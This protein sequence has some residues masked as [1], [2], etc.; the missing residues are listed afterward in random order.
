MTGQPRNI[1][2]ISGLGADHRIFENLVP[3]EGYRLK[4]IPWITQQKNESI[5]HYAARM[6]A[7]IRDPEPVLIGVS[8]GGM[9]SVEIAKQRPGSQVIMVSSI[10]TKHEK[11]FYFRAAS[12]FRL[13]KIL[14][15]R[16]YR[17]LE[18]LENYNLGI[19]TTDEKKLAREYRKN[20]D[21]NYSNWAI[22]RIIHWQNEFIPARIV[23][24][25]GSKDHIFPIKYVEPGYVIEG[26]GH[27]MIHNRA[28][29]IS[30]I[31]SDT[32]Q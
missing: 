10:K 26:G 19:K 20:L 14:P 4:H 15:L 24:I 31:I 3:P 18:P 8:F 21:I 17:F 1:Y 28:G 12:L 27:L 16:P 22:E 13:N 11:P 29:D 32:L 6:A 9:V 7:A 5:E 2:C 23:H 30:R 25:H